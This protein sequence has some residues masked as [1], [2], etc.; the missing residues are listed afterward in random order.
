MEKSLIIDKRQDSYG[1]FFSDN[2]GHLAFAASDDAPLLAVPIFDLVADWRSASY[3]GALPASIP[4]AIK[5]FHDT[6]VKAETTATGILQYSDVILTKL[7]REL[8]ELVDSPE[9]QRILRERLVILT[10]EIAEA[11]SSVKQELDGEAVWQQYLSINP[12]HMG[13]HGTMRLVYLAVYGAYENFVVHALSIAHGGKRIRVT[14]RDFKENFRAVLG[15]FIDDAWFAKDIHV[16]RLIR[17]ALIHAGGRVTNDLR[18]CDI[19]LLVHEGI[20]NVFPEHISELYDTL[21]GPALTI[22]KA[23]CFRESSS[24]PSDVH[25]TSEASS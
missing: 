4:N 19:P 23:S 16:A 24:K 22:M 21:K 20:L 25:Q 13:L 14:D 6:F 12:F 5:Q 15:D 11:N 10:S 8:P 7:S 2:F 3:V 9:L 1:T 18:N 17:H